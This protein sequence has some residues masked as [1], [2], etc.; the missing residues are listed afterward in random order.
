MAW[1]A[2]RIPRQLL[3]AEP[4]P[5][6]EGKPLVL[7]CRTSKEEYVI[8][9]AEAYFDTTHFYLKKKSDTS[10][11]RYDALELR[12][13]LQFDASR[14]KETE[15]IFNAGAMSLLNPCVE[16]HVLQHKRKRIMRSR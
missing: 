16:A 6:H 7:W 13:Q 15:G 14:L 10:E 12:E 5:M 4:K 3:V 8:S 1:S 2:R 11:L 9:E